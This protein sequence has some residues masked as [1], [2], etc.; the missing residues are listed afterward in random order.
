MHADVHSAASAPL[1]ERRRTFWPLHLHAICRDKCAAA[2]KTFLI[3]HTPRFSTPAVAKLKNGCVITQRRGIWTKNLR[4]D[5]I[6]TPEFFKQ[7]RKI[8]FFRKSWSTVRRASR[9]NLLCWLQLYKQ[10]NSWLAVIWRRRYPLWCC[11]PVHLPPVQYCV[12]KSTPVWII[13]A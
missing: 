3:K 11:A 2:V 4:W 9:I 7:Q 6:C 10:L 1:C 5:F 13:L 12:S 8:I